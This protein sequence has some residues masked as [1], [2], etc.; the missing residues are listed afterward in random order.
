[1]MLGGLSTGSVSKS[2]CI[3]FIYIDALMSTKRR[4]NHFFGPKNYLTSSLFLVMQHRIFRYL[5]TCQ[6]RNNNMAPRSRF[7]FSAKEVI[8]LSAFTLV[9]F[10][11]AFRLGTLLRDSSV[12]ITYRA[13]S[14][15][16]SQKFRPS[17][18][19]KL[20]T[21]CAIDTSKGSPSEDPFFETEE[22]VLRLR[23]ERDKVASSV[24]FPLN[25]I[26]R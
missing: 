11:H 7:V 4:L 6:G 17:F 5:T 9:S 18:S 19:S 21:K 14:A 13:I 24:S 20:P 15:A 26:A 16:T 3:G 8:I 25:F 23:S 10:T 2:Q 1:M 22:V 12:Q